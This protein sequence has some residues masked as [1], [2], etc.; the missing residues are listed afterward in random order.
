MSSV[1]RIF[2]I[3]LLVAYAFVS[4][5][6][7]SG[8][9]NLPAGRGS[10]PFGGGTGSKR[11]IVRF[12]RAAGRLTEARE[13]TANASELEGKAASKLIGKARKAE[14]A[15]SRLA[16]RILSKGTDE[17]RLALKVRLNEEARPSAARGMS[18]P[19]GA[20]RTQLAKALGEYRAA[21][22]MRSNRIFVRMRWSGKAF[23]SIDRATKRAERRAA[24]LVVEAYDDVDVDSHSIVRAL[25]ANGRMAGHDIHLPENATAKKIVEAGINII[26]LR[27]AY[28]AHF[29]RE[30]STVAAV[31]S[32]VFTGLG[33]VFLAL[34]GISR[35][36]SSTVGGLMTTVGLLL[37]T[38]SSLARTKLVAEHA[39][40]L[41][42]PLGRFFKLSP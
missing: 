5:A 13:L 30:A 26:A 18:L 28:D 20:Q 8:A 14:S 31:A 17:D 15:A 22:L 7:V 39:E 23:R 19:P 40:P 29:L 16:D 10:L 4:T 36:Y 1:V 33:V 24:E 38:L 32:V 35:D 11:D 6:S 2:S 27:K 37:L 3:F 9:V 25:V 12:A 42:D 34:P 21:E 41:E